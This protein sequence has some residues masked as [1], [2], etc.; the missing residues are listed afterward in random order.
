MVVAA[1]GLSGAVYGGSEALIAAG[2]QA[3]DQQPIEPTQEV[4]AEKPE[5]PAIAAGPTEIR[6]GGYLGITGIYRSTLNGGGPGSNFATVP[7]S[8]SAEGNLS[9][10]RWTAQSSRLSIRVN[11][12][13]AVGV[14]DTALVAEANCLA[15]RQRSLVGQ[16]RALFH[17]AQ[18]QPAMNLS[19]AK[20]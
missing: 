16:R 18:I 8:D 3:V 7:Y 11:A 10:A 9:E 14:D 13:P 6:I 15:W 4:A 2:Q 20:S 1:L 12:A 5:G 17:P 19:N